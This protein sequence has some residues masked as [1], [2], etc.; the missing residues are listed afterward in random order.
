MFS[1]SKLVRI[2]VKHQP[3]SRTVL[4]I[5]ST[6]CTIASQPAKIDVDAI[7]HSPE[8][9]NDE[10]APRREQVVNKTQ[11]DAMKNLLNEFHD[12]SSDE[13]GIRTP[14]SN[15]DPSESAAMEMSMD[16]MEFLSDFDGYPSTIDMIYENIPW[17]NHTFNNKLISIALKSDD[18]SLKWEI[19][20]ENDIINLNGPKQVI[21]A[22]IKQFTNISNITNKIKI[23]WHVLRFLTNNG[24]IQSITNKH[25]IIPFITA[26]DA[27]YSLLSYYPFKSEIPLNDT[28]NIIKDLNILNELGEEKANIIHELQKTKLSSIDEIININFIMWKHVEMD[29]KK[30][31]FLK[32]PHINDI[33]VIMPIINDTIE[34]NT[35]VIPI[36]DKIANIMKSRTYSWKIEDVLDKYDKQDTVHVAISINP[37]MI[38]II[39]NHINDRQIIEPE[40]RKLIPVCERI[41]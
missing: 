31:Y 38:I 6:Y 41:Y 7:V 34:K 4:Q 32:S 10:I 1:C 11:L 29:D 12:T 28:I 13:E 16:D 23:P 19:D 17:A 5:T 37:S 27:M 33:N 14:I 26:Y 18:N 3:L 40:I 36:D 25:N 2:V 20:Y 30:H 22:R 24:I 39:S 35:T 8:E 15:Y 9:F 21:I